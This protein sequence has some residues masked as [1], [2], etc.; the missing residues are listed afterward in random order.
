MKLSS[1]GN[2]VALVAALLIGLA[3]SSSAQQNSSPQNSEVT[4]RDAYN[5]QALSVDEAP[6]VGFDTAIISPT[7]TD[8]P[9]NTLRA[10]RADCVNIGDTV[11]VRSDGVVAVSTTGLPITGSQGFVIYGYNNISHFSA[12]SPSG[13][14]STIY[15][16]FSRVP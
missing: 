12:I 3:S 4:F 8:C 16:Q 9:I 7:C 14:S 11:W 10:T 2:R 1:L 5:V 13:D 15:C 6:A